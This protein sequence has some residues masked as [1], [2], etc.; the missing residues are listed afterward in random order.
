MDHCHFNYHVIIIIS[1]II[2]PYHYPDHV[3]S[4]YIINQINH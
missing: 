4:D 2:N 1:L 3:Y